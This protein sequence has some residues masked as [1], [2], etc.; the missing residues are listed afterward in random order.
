MEK[1]EEVK[2]EDSFEFND[3]EEMVKKTNN[4]DE[5]EKNEVDNSEENLNEESE[6]ENEGEEYEEE[7][8]DKNEEENEE[9]DVEDNKEENKEKCYG[10]EEEG[11][12]EKASNLMNEF[13]KKE[14]I[15]SIVLEEN[16][17]FMNEENELRRI[18]NEESEENKIE[19][20]PIKKN[21]KVLKKLKIVAEEMLKKMENEKKEEEKLK[22]KLKEREIVMKKIFEIEAEL[23]SDNEDNDDNIKEINRNAEDEK[24]EEGSID[25]ELKKMIVDEKEIE[26]E[27]LLNDPENE[28]LMDKFQKDWLKKDKEEILEIIRGGF[29]NK[30]RNKGLLNDGFYNDFQ[31]KKK[32]KMVEERL[33]RLQKQNEGG[34]FNE[35]KELFDR[36]K[37]KKELLDYKLIPS[38]EEEQLE[39]RKL[40]KIKKNLEFEGKKGFSKNNT[41]KEEDEN[42][43][44]EKVYDNFLEK[45]ID[46]NS[47]KLS[48]NNQNL[49]NSVLFVQKDKKNIS[50]FNNCFN[51]NI[52]NDYGNNMLKVFGE[53]KKE[54]TCNS[55]NLNKLFEQKELTK[56]KSSKNFV[57]HKKKLKTH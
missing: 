51:K 5:D 15:N 3:E 42:L 24:D 43:I 1:Q 25:E 32:L 41:F 9:E 56:V 53:R 23:G 34:Y 55:S 6:G 38:N 11:E 31:T 57:F 30:K 52:F 12:N 54:N 44:D 29:F 33:E 20:E 13:K 47:K 2:E 39:M 37:S 28:L 8:E 14:N 26:E 16:S 18:N 35:G 40:I 17:N 49:K 46:D 21:R 22:I 50:L 36:E 10:D 27:L 45:K 4:N 7:N 19:G 48:E